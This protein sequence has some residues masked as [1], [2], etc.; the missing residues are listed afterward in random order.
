MMG[1]RK[2]SK[3]KRTRTRPAT[4]CAIREDFNIVATGVGGQGVLTMAE[5]I[6]ESALKQG[7]DV[8]MSELHG[9]SQRGGSIPC[10]VRFGRKINSSLV[11]LGEADVIVAMEP[12]EALRSAKYGSKGRTTI[13]S[14]T[15]R[16]D[17]VSVTFQGMKYPKLEDIEKRLGAFA[18]KVVLVDAPGIAMR[19]TGS[20]V[21]SNIY[22]LGILSARGILPIR[23]TILL[24][25]IKETVPAKSFEQNKRVFE[26]AK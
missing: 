6:A 24:E 16:I 23:R 18:K 2:I 19:E 26:M 10:Q 17:P 22:L 21:A 9:L 25:T 8:K 7:F 20:T 11:R 14:S 15:Q 4:G 13:L 5:I 3:A 12:L 1:T